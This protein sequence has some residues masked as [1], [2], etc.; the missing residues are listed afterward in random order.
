[1]KKYYKILVIILKNAYIRDSKIPGYIFMNLMFQFAEMTVTIIFFNVIFENTKTL[2]GWNFYQV[3][4]LY[5]FARM[6]FSLHKAFFRGG[7]NL[8]SG[9]LIRNG[10]YDFY[11]TKPVNSLFLASVNKP[12]IY[13]FIAIIFQIGIA[14]WAIVIGNLAISTLSVFWFIYLAILASI[15]LYYL[16]VLT[17]TPVFW[18]IKVWSLRDVVPRLQAFMRYPLGV[19]PGYLKIILMGIFP[20]MATSYIPVRTLFYPPEMKYILYMTLITL[21]F[22]FIGRW[23]WKLG[24]KNYGSASS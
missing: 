9:N 18:L 21:I 11:L 23:F 8:I 22:V 17:V 7:F 2:V 5:M 12:R 14:I 16:A 20:I 15:L 19:F 4:F 13:E 3:L 24:E 1:M 10:D 6:T